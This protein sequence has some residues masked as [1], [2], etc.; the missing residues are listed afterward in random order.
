LVEV[1]GL[2]HRNR[3]L[4]LYQAAERD[5]AA[6]DARKGLVIHAAVA[7]VVSVALAIMNVFVAPEFPW[8]IFPFLGM[9]VGVGFHGYFGVHRGEEFMER[10]Q[11]EVQA[12][13]A[14]RNAA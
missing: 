13:A 7:V 2:A 3:R 11:H 14:R 4:E 12:G 8:S 10:H 5:R 9:S 6:V 1:P